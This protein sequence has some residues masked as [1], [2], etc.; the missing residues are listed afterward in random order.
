M[1]VAMRADGGPEIG[2]GHLVRSGAF[3]E[4]V[5]T[6]DHKV[7]VS[8]TAP[9]TAKA[10]FPDGTEIVDLPVRDNPAPF[11]EWLQNTT[12][13]VV[14]TD[15][16]TVD[17]E[18][19]RAIRNQVPLAVLQDDARHS[20]CADL[21]VNGNLYADDLNYEFVGQKP[22]T[23]L[24]T[25]YVFLRREIRNLVSRE[26][27]WREGPE[28]A[29]VMMGGSDIADVTPTVV[30]AFDGFELKV[31]AIV[32]PGFSSKQERQVWQAADDCSADVHVSRNPDDLVE[33][34]FEADFAVSTAS[35]TTYELLALGTP[36]VSLPVVDNQDL[37]AEALHER[38]AATVLARKSG[39]EDFHRAI[40]SYVENPD[41]R[42][43]RRDRGRDLVDGRGTE[44][45]FAEVLS[46]VEEHR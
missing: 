18:Y 38:D 39:L 8:T 10:V 14:F 37:I 4:E 3:A 21:F 24:G 17:T 27:P 2:Y 9:Q 19:Q 41:L 30:H 33:R 31:D 32:G 6:G 1:E 46:I 13:N 29:L 42:R 25:D 15:S 23:C 34:M 16:Y 40:E 22:H 26:P 20:I 44:R 7:T 28:R 12:T 45:V 5:I 35:S 36:I 11:V 43:K